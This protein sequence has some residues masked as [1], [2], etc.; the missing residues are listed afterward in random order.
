[1]DTS[2][3][4]VG[5]AGELRIL[6][7][8]LESRQA[9][10]IAVI[11]R[12]RVGKTFLVRT[13]FKDDIV[14]EM[15]GMY[16]GSM[17]DQLAIFAEKLT[18]YSGS[19]FPLQKPTS[20]LEAFR[21]LKTYVRRLDPGTKKVV[22]L[23]ELPW[24]ATRRSG[25]LGALG[26]FWNDWASQQKIVLVI[27]GSAAS[28]M[29]EKVIKHKGGLHNRV[30]KLIQLEPFMLDE[31]EEYLY[32][33]NIRLD[34]YQIIQLYMAMGGIPHYLK[35]IK[36]GETATQSIDRICF[37]KNGLLKSEFEN[38]YAALY[39]HPESHVRVIHV[40]ASKWKGVTR[41]EIAEAG[42]I[43]NGG[44]LTRV[45]EQLIQASFITAYQAFGKRK[46]EILYRLTDEYYL[47]YLKFIREVTSSKPGTWMQLSQ[48]QKWK[49]W[50]GFAFE[51]L[52]LKHVENIKQ[53]LG[54][55]GIH[56]QESSFTIRGSKDTEGFQIDLLIDRADRA[57]NIC[58]VKYYIGKY[59]LTK[60]QAVQLRQKRERFRSLTRTKKQL[61]IT[62]I[63]TY[64]LEHNAYSLGLIDQVITMEDLF[65]GLTAYKNRT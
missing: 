22:F 8:A 10:M 36:A 12:R 29:I 6:R 65:G 24:I 43:S 50:S 56:T 57:I 33:R 45:L 47:F 58:E 5:R 23:D 11:G 20:W 4:F 62:L 60:D 19:E 34:K 63:T 49:S 17:A 27:C 1:M 59:A 18:E 54:I 42:K 14:F 25:F 26:H 55:A 39:E 41:K 28:W 61:F 51:S 21:L 48:S 44:S 3:G 30:T 9:H 32:E 15:T 31:T 52:C 35:E 37:V 7:E 2:Q 38:L 40:L 53:T 46:K 13:A 64:G 16:R